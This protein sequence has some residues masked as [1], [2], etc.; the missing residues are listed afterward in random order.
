VGEIRGL[1]PS[2]HTTDL[3]G[4]SANASGTASAHAGGSATGHGQGTFEYVQAVVIFFNEYFNEYYCK[5]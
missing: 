2:R 4:H 1:L 3:L 5:R